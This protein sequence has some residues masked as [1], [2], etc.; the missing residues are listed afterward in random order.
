MPN[1]TK[2]KKQKNGTVGGG[3]EPEEI[4]FYYDPIMERWS[5][6]TKRI[7][8]Y[9]LKDIIVYGKK[10]D[11]KARRERLEREWEEMKR[12]AERRY[13]YFWEGRD[14]SIRNRIYGGASGGRYGGGGYGGSGGRRD[15]VP[16][17]KPFESELEE[18]IRDVEYEL[19]KKLEEWMWLIDLLSQFIDNLADLIRDLTWEEL[20]ALLKAFKEILDADPH[21]FDDIIDYVKKTGKKITLRFMSGDKIATEYRYSNPKDPYPPDYLSGLS[22]SKKI[23][24]ATEILEDGKDWYY[25]ESDDKAVLELFHVLVHE[26]AHLKIRIKY[27]DTHNKEYE[28]NPNTIENEVIDLENK[29]I[30]KVRGPEFRRKK[31]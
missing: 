31:K 16:A 5:T 14:N 25:T 17:K 11:D 7:P 24:I 26:F 23:L 6:R 12:R 10:Q 18:E 9:D 27:G 19:K 22:D 1:G 3:G 20:L 29:I 15:T 28:K 30:E 13:K 8:S 4:E 21:F 2:I